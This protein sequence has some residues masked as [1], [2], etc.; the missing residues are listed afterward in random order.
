MKI[1][2]SPDFMDLTV[3]S[4]LER[5]PHKFGKLLQQIRKAITTDSF[6]LY[7]PQILH[8]D[9]LKQKVQIEILIEIVFWFV[10][11]FR[12]RFGFRLVQQGSS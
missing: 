11:R 12:L 2:I 8:Q 9:A 7:G 5:R 6:F 4:R 3:G 1:H 10:F